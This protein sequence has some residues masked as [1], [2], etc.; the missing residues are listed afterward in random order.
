[1]PDTCDGKLAGQ[2]TKV[3]GH[4]PKQG[5][6]RKWYINWDDIDRTATQIANKG[7]KVT[8]LVLKTGKKI[9]RA[10]GNKKTSSVESALAVKDF[11]NGYIHTDRFTILYKGEN[12][13]LRVQDLVEGS[14]VVTL[15]ERV[16][17]GI[18][19]ELSFEIAGYESGMSITE[20]NF[21]SAA[22]SGVT[23]ISVATSE[24]EEEA[25]ALKLLALVGGVTAVEAWIATSEYVVV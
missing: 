7:T 10:E 18:N 8:A 6:S 19:G 12:E 17:K 9:Y 24:G 11:G 22:D 13:R 23:K 1:M 5:V 14:R 21:N 15:I 20:D 3:C 2:F 25:T 4:R 16:D